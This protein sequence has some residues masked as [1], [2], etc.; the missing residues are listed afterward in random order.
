MSK[1]T[2][3]IVHAVAELETRVEAKV[4]AAS[5]AAAVAGFATTLAFHG[6]TVPEIITAA[7]GAAV[8]G[9]LTFAAGWLA[10]HTPRVSDIPAA[11]ATAASVP[12]VPAG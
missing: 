12:Q 8:T 9:G 2:P 10:K 7:V 6:G 1:L 11:P 3:V 5:T 4:K